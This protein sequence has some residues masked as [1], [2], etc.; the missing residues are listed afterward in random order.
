[1]KVLKK[2]KDNLLYHSFDHL[3]RI[4]LKYDE[5]IIENETFETIKMDKK[6]N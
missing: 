2:N 6:Q 1:M 3:L 5:R 4:S